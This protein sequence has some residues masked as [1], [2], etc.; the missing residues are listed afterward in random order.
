MLGEGFIIFNAGEPFFLYRGQYV[1]AADWGKETDYTVVSV[2]RI[3]V[4][5]YELV[6]FLKVNRRP[7]P[8]MIGWF[9]AA[10]NKY[11]A[12][13]IHDATGLGEQPRP[14]DGRVRQV[15][16]VRRPGG[17]AGIE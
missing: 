17:R 9:N 8:Q 4:Q 2:A 3:D 1:A 13:A 16:P 6:Y 10:I 12:E 14:V 11:A 5:P 15:A 7:Y